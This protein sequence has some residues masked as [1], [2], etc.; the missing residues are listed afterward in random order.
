MCLL[1]QGYML[2]TLPAS[3]AL[4]LLALSPHAWCHAAVPTGEAVAFPEVLVIPQLC[5]LGTVLLLS[6]RSSV[7]THDGWDQEGHGACKGHTLPW[8]PA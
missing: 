5:F 2:Q 4:A 6:C 3:T 1:L 8:D 7:G